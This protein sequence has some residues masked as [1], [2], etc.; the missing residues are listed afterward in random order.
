[1]TSSAILTLLSSSLLSSSYLDYD[2]ISV[3]Y[4]VEFIFEVVEVSL[5]QLQLFGEFTDDGFLLIQLFTQLL[6]QDRVL[7]FCS[8]IKK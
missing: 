8:E 1:M 4:L 7:F 5:V 3:S 6:A 2:V